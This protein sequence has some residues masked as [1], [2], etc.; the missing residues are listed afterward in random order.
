MSE[1]QARV[2]HLVIVADTL[3]QGVDWCERT[4]GVAPGPGGEHPLM[5]THNRL[6]RIATVDY[7]RAYL[8]IIAIDPAA[9]PA[10]RAPGA[11]WF[12]MDQAALR[13]RVAQQGPLLAHFVANVPDLQAAVGALAAQGIDRGEPL[14][15]S[16]ATPH[17]LLRWKITWRPDGQ[18]LFDGALPT[19]IEW[20]STH[21][22]ATMPD[23]GLRLQQLS[24]TH[25][26]HESLRAAYDTIG[27]HGVTVSAGAPNVCATLLTPR[28]TVRL[29]S[30][31][32]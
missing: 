16:R 9:K 3:A 1:S 21:P 27:L 23:S 19:L 22:A 24:V 30:L 10:S 28:G 20:G 32:L 18:R 17:G 7:P 2:D 11:R 12:D 14:E 29:Q 26:R 8:E 31:A 4:L 13:E 6:L 5:G 25:P 15:A